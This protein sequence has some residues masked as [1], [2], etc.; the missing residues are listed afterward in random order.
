M[1]DEQTRDTAARRLENFPP[2]RG[3]GIQVLQLRED[4]RSM[5][6]LLPLNEANCNPGHSMFGGCI[7]SLADPIPA[8][9]CNQVFP[10][11][12]VWTRELQ[13]DFRRPGV[14]DLELR[15]EFAQ[16]AIEEIERDL[17]RRG[18]STPMFEFGFYDRQEQLVAWIKNRVAIRPL[19]FSAG[20]TGEPSTS[21][22]SRR[23]KS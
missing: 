16:E 15:F 4:W 17:S 2:F 22:T 7:A 23:E 5:R 11:H 12:A 21:R 8:L 1:Y 18:R 14:S 3:L 10:G 6:I 20:K 19:E 13:V 9:A